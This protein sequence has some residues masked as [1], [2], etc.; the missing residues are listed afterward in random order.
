MNPLCS[1]ATLRVTAVKLTL[2]KNTAMTWKSTV[3]NA[4]KVSAASPK[5]TT[6]L[7][8]STSIATNSPKEVGSTLRMT[9][10]LSKKKMWNTHTTRANSTSNNME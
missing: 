4:P 1:H 6:I 8:R 9:Q 10:L 2:V 7:G 3:S 5:S